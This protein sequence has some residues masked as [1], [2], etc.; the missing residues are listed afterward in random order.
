VSLSLFNLAEQL[1]QLA[2]LRVQ[3]DEKIKVRFASLLDFLTCPA[4]V[5]NELKIHTIIRL[6]NRILKNSV[7]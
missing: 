6:N 5:E 7:I 2:M 3:L 1:S 4:P